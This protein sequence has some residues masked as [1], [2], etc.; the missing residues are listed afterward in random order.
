MKK[1]ILFLVAVLCFSACKTDLTDI[2]KRIEEIEKQGKTLE[3]QNQEYQEQLNDLKNQGNQISEEARKRQEENEKIQQQL[4][5]L[6]DSL[7]YVEPYLY[8]ME[9]VAA[10]NPYQLIENTPCTI[11]GD[12]VVECRIL[13]ITDDRMLIPR[14]TFQGSVVTINGE[15]AESGKKA[16]DFSTPVVLSVITA[17]KIKD[18][19]VYVNSYTGLPSVWLDTNSHVN[20]ANANQYY[21]GSIKIIDGPKTRAGSGVTK[22]SVKIMGLSPI[23]WYRPDFI[24]SNSED[25]LLAKNGYFL[26]FN[27][28]ISLFNEPKGT[29]W[30]LLPNL[31]DMTFL[32]NQT[33][34][35]MGRISKL[36]YTPRAHY[37][38][39]FMN[40][41]FFGNYVMTERPDLTEER[42][43][44]GSDGFILNIGSDEAGQYFYGTYLERPVT[45]MAPGSPSAEY[46][47]YANDFV[48]KAE[49]A[50]FSS[51]FTDENAGWQKY[52]DMDSF[53]DWYL[54]NEIARNQDGAFS[55]NCL[56]NLA[57][58]GKLKMGPLWDFEKA[59]GNTTKKEPAEGFVIKGVKW[60]E[61]LF[62]DPAFV[63]KVKERFDYFYTHQQDI[64]SE[65]NANAEYLRYSVKEDDYRW[66]TYAG[67]KSSTVSVWAAYG[68][69]VDYMKQWLVARMDWLK[70]EFDAM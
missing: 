27:N 62:Q 56:M 66:D 37:V 20:V 18:Y 45:V 50:L 59:F 17:S 5:E 38:D 63:A 64:L 7:H 41:R 70:K 3:E 55:K 10:D 46:V 21:G 42:V 49:N 60:Y 1:C 26:K 40:S 51:S 30:R 69:M 22:A 36:E 67:Y 33:A 23:R 32:H 61:R 54:I 65:I 9:F 2:E 6:E 29:T 57:R 24:L 15:E 4:R 43:N 68:S 58:G 35:F 12:S 31:N 39:M 13:N 14:F 48:V 53:V 52:M 28:N 8:T 47:S 34:F 16:Y 25:L 44:I 19:V 11:I